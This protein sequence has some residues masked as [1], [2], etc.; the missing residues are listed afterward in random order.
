M[1]KIY[2]KSVF[3]IFLFLYLV[4]THF[5]GLSLRPLHH[6]E[7][8]HSYYSWW[9]SRG[10][11]Y[12][13]DPM[14][15]GTFLFHTNA[16]IYRLLGA[17]DFTSRLLPAFV[18]VGLIALIFALRPFQG[19]VATW[20]AAILAA[21]SPSFTYYSRFI[22]NDIYI[23]F[24]SLAMV[25]TLLKFLQ[26][27][28]QKYITG[29]TVFFALSVCTKENALIT[30][31]IFI[32]Y[33]LLQ[34]LYQGFI[35]PQPIPALR[36][37]ASFYYHYL[38]K[39]FHSFLS[40]GLLL[41]IIYLL[42]YTTFLTNPQG[43]KAVIMG[44]RY[45][46]AQHQK[47]RIGDVF[48]YYLPLLLLY[49]FVATA[50]VITGIFYLVFKTYRRLNLLAAW[51]IV[52]LLLYLI[53]R[54]MTG[55]LTR[56][57]FIPSDMVVF[58]TIL[59]LGFLTTHYFWK[60]KKYLPAFYSYWSVTSFLIYSSLGEKVPWL[61]LHLLLPLIL[62]AGYFLG[63]FWK[64]KS[65]LKK[66][67]LGMLCLMSIITIYLNFNLNFRNDAPR[68]QEKISHRELLVYVQTTYDI[69]ELV[70]KVQQVV[71]NTKGQENPSITI[72]GEATWPL[73]WYLREYPV[74]YVSSFIRFDTPII[75]TD[76]ENHIRLERALTPYY[77]G[78]RYQ[79][80]GWW[81]PQ[82]RKANFRQLGNYFLFREIF[83]SP[84][85]TDIVFYFQKDLQ[86]KPP[87]ISLSP[88]VLPPSDTVPILS[89]EIIAIQGGLGEEPGKFFE[90]RDIAVDRQGNVYVV[91]SRNNRIQKFT[92]EGKFLIQWGK[93]GKGRGEFN[94]PTGVAVDKE[95]I[96]YI[97]DTWNHR[98]QKF[99]SQGEFLLAWGN[100]K[101]FWGP[102]G[103]AVDSTRNI[104]ITDTGYKRI[105]KFDPRGELLLEWGKEGSGSGEFI[106]PVG[107][108]IDKN[109]RVYIADI[110][111]RRIQVF[112]SQGIYLYQ[113]GVLG[114]EEFYSEPYLEIDERGRIFLTD[115]HHHRLQIY[116]REGKLLGIMGRQG[117][118]PG[119]FNLPMGIGLDQ[120]GYLYLA[121]TG[122]HRIQ[123]LRIPDLK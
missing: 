41:I 109:N 64:I 32:S 57:H 113:W 121:D 44:A 19:E 33:L 9:F 37:R 54:R 115:S 81:I 69:K 83:G 20:T 49:E 35:S 34:E 53:T 102:R 98:I 106:E 122:N 67:V 118:N 47:Q 30:A 12:R 16:F 3:L 17:N 50:I 13:Y 116:S 120:Q 95:G 42:F 73:S 89:L 65:W 84:G 61:F 70:N 75:I 10:H 79:L 114:W 112:D 46:W 96:V 5:W 93:A 1:G 78:K 43:W 31:F 62:L 108:A 80:R 26:T 38:R 11:P 87:V 6:D 63:E 52:S 90:P 36:K 27:K 24:F 45:W 8:L 18:G 99:T 74:N 48:T 92:A 2:W 86:H 28:N 72:Q 105:K 77:E 66:P 39:N 110:G 76:W 25:V 59:F 88:P 104:Y 94:S 22:R 111:N 103:I 91:D 51:A 23:A 68:P 15:H 82:W 101:T 123:K 100:E 107:I 14:M 29:I 71:G 56:Y 60:R 4:F 117:I 7:S 21:I 55:F 85:S 119:E 40:W 58:W 97:A